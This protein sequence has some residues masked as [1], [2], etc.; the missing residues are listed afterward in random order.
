MEFSAVD[1]G[2]N[3]P[4]GDLPA[5]EEVLLWHDAV[6]ERLE[7]M[8]LYFW[9]LAF[10]PRY[11]RKQ[12]FDGLRHF[13]EEAR[14]T[15]YVVYET[16]GNYD[17]LLRVWAPRAYNPEEL[18]LLLRQSLE[19]CYL[20]NLNYLSCK[21]ELHF[22][23]NGQGDEQLSRELLETVS[24]RVIDAVNQYN[25][26]QWK[27]HAEK[28]E[29]PDRPITRPH[30][31]DE[32]IESGVLRVV[33]LD[34][35]GIRMFIT[36][37]YPRQ[38]FRPETRAWAVNTI[39]EKC[40]EIRELWQNRTEQLESGEERTIPAPNFS[41]YAGAGS[42]TDFMVMVRAPHK[43][44]HEFVRQVI[45]GIREIGLDDNYEMRPYTHVVADR[46][47][48]AFREHRVLGEQA[49]DVANLLQKEESE[50]LELKATLAVNFR[51]LVAADRRDADPAMLDEVVKTVCGM[52][53]SPEGGALVIG[54]LEVGR[55]LEKVKHPQQY[56]EV[57][58]EQYDYTPL[59]DEGNVTYPNA[60]LGI[61]VDLDPGP[62]Q[63]PD[64]YKRHLR[65]ALKT[66]LSGS[67]L[68]WLQI[69]TKEVAEGK[70]VCVVW[71]RPAD[72][73]FYAT[74]ENSPREEFFVREGAS[75]P[76]L[77]GA[78]GDLYK[79][80]YSRRRPQADGRLERDE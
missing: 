6:H 39:R 66:R 29:V 75:T 19:G 40:K 12:V 70:T 26:L 62:F 67:A 42:M 22:A 47:F 17:L 41:I 58:E 71:V 11:S 1:L 77:S 46:M 23:E 10:A 53:N 68:P 28:S 2:S 44:F 49:T 7:S 38:P 4:Q 69:E 65:D 48:S 59:D 21:T 54:V 5:R 27:H 76:A 9:R 55:E 80:V 18:E 60:V 33:G 57:L 34:T 73:W 72:V 13:Y 15:S 20:W 25:A 64:A 43:H 32:L 51:S 50:S 16:L 61:D 36:F 8:Q 24:V 78:A 37:D 45:D 14:I 35:R 63:D 3:L 74:V 52:L 79:Q 31:V 30:Y 56:L